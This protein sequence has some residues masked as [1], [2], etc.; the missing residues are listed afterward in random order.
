MQ[1]ATLSHILVT[2]AEKLGNLLRKSTAGFEGTRQELVAHAAR[3]LGVNTSRLICAIGFNP[4]LREV[5]SELAALGYSGYDELAAERNGI[6]VNDIYRKVSI[7]DVLA[8]YSTVSQDPALLHVMQYLLTARLQKIEGRIEQTVNPMVIER[9]KKEM[10]A[11]YADGV[12]Q[13]EFAEARLNNTDSGFRALVDE[14]NIIVD[15]RLIPVGDIFFR[16]TILP[17]EKRRLLNRGL[18]PKE[19]VLARLEEESVPVQERVMLEDYL[20]HG[21]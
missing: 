10:R 14:V 3:K 6:F 8:I 4:R 16:D 9:Y 20:E 18:I 13:I 19:L 7:D 15:S 2:N 5:D 21:A 12:A 17:A 11:I 1:M